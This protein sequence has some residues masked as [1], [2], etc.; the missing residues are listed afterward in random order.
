M[1]RKDTITP[2]FIGKK[3]KIENGGKL[4]KEVLIRIEHL[5]LKFGDLVMT[6]IVPVCKKKNK[7]KN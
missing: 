7:V 4:K 6:K 5:G 2:L 3:V 1:L